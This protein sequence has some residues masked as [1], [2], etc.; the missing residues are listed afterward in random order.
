MTLTKE[1]TRALRAFV[2]AKAKAYVAGGSYDDAS[3]TADD[4]TNAIGAFDVLGAFRALE[5]LEKSGLVVWHRASSVPG[6]WMPTS[7]AARA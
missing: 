1:Q 7:A 2:I 5:D 6:Y 3:F 4:A